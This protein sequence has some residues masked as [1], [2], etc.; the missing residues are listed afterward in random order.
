MNCTICDNEIDPL[1]LEVIPETTLC[2]DCSSKHA[3][4]KVGYMVFSHKTA[5]EIV[6]VDTN[7]KEGI[8]RAKR[9]NSRSR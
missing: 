8:R 4:S 5:P 1:R 7:D 6:I 9:A 2:F 3:P